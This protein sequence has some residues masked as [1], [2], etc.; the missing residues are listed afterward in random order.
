MR[1]PPAAAL[2]LCGLGGVASAAQSAANAELGQRIGSP[3]LAALT[4]I[5]VGWAVLLA[6]WPLLPVAAGRLRDRLRRPP[7]RRLPWWTYLGGAGGAFFVAAGAFAVPV[8]GVAAFAIAQVTGSGAGALAVDRAGLAPAGRL[9]VTWPRVGGALLGMA[10]VAL[11]Q[12]GRPVGDLTPGFLLLGVCAGAAV[13]VQSALNGRVAVAGGP[14]AGTVVNYLVALPLLAA[15][16]AGAGLAGPGWP[17]AWPTQW[18]LYLGGALGVVIVTTLVVTVPVV[19]VL[20]SGLLLVAG[21]LAGALVLDAAIPGGPR[22]SL[23]L[24]VGALLALV[25]SWVAALRRGAAP[26]G[27]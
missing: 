18:Y 27:G 4:N 1:V 13:S 7:G 12:V 14:V 3:A 22:P 5:V 10:A 11:S 19:G 6:A 2:V 9:Q 25:A 16:A 17:S 26:A 15:F 21:Q 8:L 20:R 24:A 23:A